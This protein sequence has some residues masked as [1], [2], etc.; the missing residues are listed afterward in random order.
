MGLV[1]TFG[2][3]LVGVLLG[4]GSFL[5]RRL[6]V[7][8]VRLMGGWLAGWLVACNPP[9][10]SLD[11]CSFMS[12]TM[13][14]LDIFVFETGLVWL[15]EEVLGGSGGGGGEDGGMERIRAVGRRLWGYFWPCSR[16]FVEMY[17]WRLRV[18]RGWRLVDNN[19]MEDR[20]VRSPSPSGQ[21]W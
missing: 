20:R 11:L 12:S 17:F 1:S 9:P 15:W 16:I 4:L 14:W 21:M 5:E 6:W 2:D 13:A 19:G 7:L 3:D 10:D 18:W 8:V